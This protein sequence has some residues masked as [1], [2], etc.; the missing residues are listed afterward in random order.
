MKK[1]VR[2]ILLTLVIGSAFGGNSLS[3]TR[4]TTALTPASVPGGG[5]PMPTCNPFTNPNCPS[6]R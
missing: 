3:K 5:G 4:L 6:I 2:L 1:A